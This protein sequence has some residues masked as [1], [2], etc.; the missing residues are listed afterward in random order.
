MATC[1][2]KLVEFR[3]IPEKRVEGGEITERIT[4]YC[5]RLPRAVVKY[6]SM[7]G[8]KTE[9]DKAKYNLLL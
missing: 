9:M 1:G 2:W 5:N 4:Q 7:K 8:L 6:L 3:T